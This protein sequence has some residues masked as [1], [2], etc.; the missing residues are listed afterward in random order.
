M[1]RSNGRPP[2]VKITSLNRHKNQTLTVAYNFRGNLT[3]TETLLVPSSKQL[4]VQQPDTG[5]ISISIS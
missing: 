2:R 1:N 3:I 5:N 4:R